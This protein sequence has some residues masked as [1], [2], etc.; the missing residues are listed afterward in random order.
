MGSFARALRRRILRDGLPP[1]FGW[2]NGEPA[3]VAKV[4]VEV[5]PAPEGWWCEGLTG[6]TRA[7]VRVEYGG[8]TFY[9]DD[10][11]PPPGYEER[12]RE[13]IAADP[14]LAALIAAAPPQPLW[15]SG[16]DGWLK[17]TEGRGAPQWGHRSLPVAVDLGVR[18]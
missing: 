11:V 9:I 18:E 15:T 14:R 2:W 17:V 6:L 12:R 5:G 13:R 10:D 4:W 7:A 1:G 8:Q 16:G 3:R